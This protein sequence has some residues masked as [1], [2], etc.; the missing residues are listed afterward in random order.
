MLGLFAFFYACLHFTTYV[1]LDQFFDPA[2]IVK[3]VI[4]RPFITVGF[5]AFVLLIPLAATSTN[6]MI[7]RLGGKTW[8]RLHYLVYLIADARRGPLLVAGEEGRHA[9]D[10]VRRRARGA[11]RVSRRPSPARQG[12]TPGS[13]SAAQVRGDRKHGGPAQRRTGV[14]GKLGAKRVATRRQPP[15]TDPRMPTLP[16]ARAGDPV[17]AIDT[18]ALVV[19][20]DALERNLDLMA[21]AV[22]GA[23]LALR[24]HAKSHKCPEIARRADRARCGR[25]LLPE[26]ERG[27]GVRRRRHPR[28]ARHQRDRRR[29]RSCARLA[30]LAHRATVGVLADDAGNVAELSAAATAAGATLDV[31]VEV[32]VGAHRCGVQPGEP[33]ARLATAI[34][35]APGLRLRGLHAYHGAAQHLRTPADAI[36]G[37]LL[38]PFGCDLAES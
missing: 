21:N 16:P 6:A 7:R 9:A 30:A 20:L 15:P 1:W 12:A 36:G 24:P 8:Q 25:H 4:K 28:R 27:R 38:R 17:A 35:R 26:G 18:P 33:A 32:D 13:R 2:A 11:A 10:A 19:D 29:R 22:R 34:A 14:R 37:L 5:S 31:L 23:G 3:D